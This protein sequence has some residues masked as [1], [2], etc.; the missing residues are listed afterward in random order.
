[1]IRMLIVIVGIA[2]AV[3][4]DSDKVS[5]SETESDS[6]ATPIKTDTEP[7]SV[8]VKDTTRSAPDRFKSTI[9]FYFTSDYCGGAA[10]SE[11]LLLQKSTPRLLTNSVMLLMKSSNPNELFSTCHTNGKGI[12]EVYLPEGK[13]NVYFTGDINPELETG[14]DGRC[15][16]WQKQIL[17][18][19]Y[20]KQDAVTKDITVHF[21]CNPC[22]VGINKRP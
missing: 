11:E 19:V 9:R 8:T 16:K 3:S 15:L 18:T 6:I 5:V 22:D 14:F 17:Q 12:G 7:D 21:F 2:F 13:Y 20:L 4:C 1:M 10:P